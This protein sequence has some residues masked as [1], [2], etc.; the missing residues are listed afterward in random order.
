[1]KKILTLTLN[2]SLDISSATAEFL[3][4]QKLRCAP[5][6]YN[7]GGGGI[8]ISRAIRNLGGESVALLTRG[9]AIGTL[10]VD[11]LNELSIPCRTFDIAGMTRQ[12]F[13]VSEQKSGDQLRFVM[14]GPHL[15]PREERNLLDFISRQAENFDYVVASGSLPP[16]MEEN[17]YGRLADILAHQDNALIV[18]TSGRDLAQAIDAPVEL[19][20]CNRWE[21][22]ELLNRPIDSIAQ[23][24]DAA[25]E[26]LHQGRCGALCVAVGAQGVLYVDRERAFHAIPPHVEII[27]MVGA[28]DSLV[29]GLVLSL[30]RGAVVEQALT[31]GMACA[32]ATIGAPGTELCAKDQVAALLPQVKFHNLNLSQI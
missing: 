14:P 22:S 19:I 4:R 5:P 17:F 26:I 15:T 24:L 7:A 1:M 25:R 30:A 6:L 3:P 16:D 28:G 20:R 2:P 31:Y 12:N 11:R 27:S 29:A 23:A 13:A 10:L 21:F 8:N 9:G 32:S 18:D